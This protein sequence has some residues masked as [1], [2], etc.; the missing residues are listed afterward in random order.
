VELKAEEGLHHLLDML[1]EPLGSDAA[2]VRDIQ[3]R[4]RFLPEVVRQQCV[5]FEGGTGAE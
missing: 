4:E 3:R 2:W 1:R 5:R